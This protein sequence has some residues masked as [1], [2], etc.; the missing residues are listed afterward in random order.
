MRLM[1]LAFR[2]METVAPTVGG[3]RAALLWCTPPAGRGRRRDDRPSSLPADR[4]TLTTPKGVRL[5]VET[6]GAPDAA[7]V[8]LVHGWGG[9]RGQLG[10]YVAPLVAAGRRVVAFDVPSHGESGPGMLGPRRATAAEFTEAL[11]A[12]TA[13]Y[14]RAAAIVAH[15]LGC[16]TTVRAVADGLAA[17]RL[18]LVAPV[19]DPLERIGD[20]T[21]LLGAGDRTRVALVERLE[22]WAG[23]PAADFTVADLPARRSMPPCLVV[24]DRDDKEVPYG[25]GRDLAESWP[26]AELV[27]TDGLGHQRILRDPEV[28]ATVTAFVTR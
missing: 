17:D 7:P 14:G 26:G 9:W 2:T 5:A 22:R 6:W 27:S 15:S 23:R 28:V 11:V 20:F 18:A 4:S 21:R 3:H 10:P 24:H 19:A 25:G 16:A 13:A 12:V 8:Y 1:R